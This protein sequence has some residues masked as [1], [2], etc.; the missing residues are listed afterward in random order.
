MYKVWECSQEKR[1]ERSFSKDFKDLFLK[2]FSEDLKEDFPFSK[3]FSEFW[4]HFHVWKYPNV[5]EI[6][7]DFPEKSVPH[8]RFQ[9][10]PSQKEKVPWVF[11]GMEWDGTKEDCHLYKNTRKA[12][13]VFK[14]CFAVSRYQGG[15]TLRRIPGSPTQHHA[16]CQ[17][18][19]LRVCE[20]LSVI[21]TDAVPVSKMCLQYQKSLKR[22]Y[23]GGLGKLIIF[24]READGDCFFICHSCFWRV[25]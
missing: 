18:S 17:S 19:D 22:G 1:Y 10:R 20:H 14:V 2:N 13:L 24:S 5:F 12:K 16:R 3:G 15:D 9:T 7:L 11:Q 4:V 25:S 6:E 21:A 8:T 23:S